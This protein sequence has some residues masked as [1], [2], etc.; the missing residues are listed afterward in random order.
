MHWGT[1]TKA[2]TDK[3]TT[4]MIYL[5][6]LL[7]FFFYLDDARDVPAVCVQLVWVCRCAWFMEASDE[8]GR[9]NLLFVLVF[10]HPFNGDLL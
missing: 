4:Y 10:L 7:F 6:P 8:V 9:F 1:L 3:L 2:H 5:L